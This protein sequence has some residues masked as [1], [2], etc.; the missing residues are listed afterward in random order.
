MN[1]KQ[2]AQ[3]FIGD[4]IPPELYGLCLQYLICTADTFDIEIQP[5]ET[6]FINKVNNWHIILT[7]KKPH[8][9]YAHT[10]NIRDA[11][12]TAIY[13]VI[14]MSRSIDPY[15]SVEW[16]FQINAEEQSYD[17]T[18]SMTFCA[19]TKDYG[20]KQVLMA[21]HSLVPWSDT[22]ASW[23]VTIK[24]QNKKQCSIAF[25]GYNFE[26][27]LKETNKD[28]YLAIDV[29]VLNYSRVEIISV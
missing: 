15:K 8:E 3:W 23:N 7:Y 25:N 13:P 20:Y 6:C 12:E 17:D 2:L 11:C 28:L 4:V 18:C 5:D 21:N 29:Q 1:D 10:P 19:T 24:I 27:E 14:R 9:G 22:R 26:T 16:K